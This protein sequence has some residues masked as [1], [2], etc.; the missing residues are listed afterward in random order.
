[1]IA[2]STN[3]KYKVVVNALECD[4]LVTVFELRPRYYIQLLTNI[5]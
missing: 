4:I 1:M 3:F 5:P 2:S